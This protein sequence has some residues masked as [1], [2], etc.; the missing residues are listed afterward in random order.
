MS[1]APL[2]G[3]HLVG[4]TL[5]DGRPVPADGKVLRHK[6]EIVPC[7]A[8]LHIIV[9]REHKRQTGGRGDA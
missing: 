6:G 2:L 9:M 3:W 1:D 8:G 7:N 5:R 4:P